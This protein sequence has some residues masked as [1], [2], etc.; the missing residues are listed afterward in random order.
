MYSFMIALVV[1][2]DE[3]S[4]VADLRPE[5][6]KYCTYFRR[7]FNSKRHGGV[8]HAFISNRFAASKL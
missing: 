8:G 6:P 3:N 5:C 2:L 4:Q 7:E 1:N